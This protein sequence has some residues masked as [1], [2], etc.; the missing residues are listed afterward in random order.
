MLHVVLEVV[1]G[2]GPLHQPETLRVLVHERRDLQGIGIVHRAPDRLA[3]PVVDLQAGGRE[4]GR[5]RVVDAPPVLGPEQVARLHAAQPEMIDRLAGEDRGRDLGGRGLGAGPEHHPQ[6]AGGGFGIDQGVQDEGAVGRAL[7]E[8]RAE[9]R[10]LLAA[11]IGRAEG[12]RAGVDAEAL[13]LG[14][15]PEERGA[16]EHREVRQVG[17][18]GKAG[19]Q[20][21]AREAR[22]LGEV[23]QGDAAG[24]EA[25][26]IVGDRPDAAVLDQE[27]RD[28][29]GEDRPAMQRLDREA[30]I[31]AGPD[32][33][34][35]LRADGAVLLAAQALEAG[36]E[37]V[38]AGRGVSAFGEGA[39]EIGHRRGV[40]GRAGRRESR[41]VLGGRRDDPQPGAG[42]DG[43]HGCEAHQVA[44]GAVSKIGACGIEA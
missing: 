34:G 21:K 30:D 12:Q 19:A 6:R 10:E 22:I 44:A 8:H 24:V 3:G 26:R 42:Q 2:P 9:D 36:R 41:G 16:L 38:G 14:D 15:E 35:G 28:A 29:A 32:R 25:R 43:A 18:V 4:G 1:V 17:P 31:V 5:A 39:G 11:G 7:D 33:G 27:Q 23:R 37:V 40:E 13:S 20:A